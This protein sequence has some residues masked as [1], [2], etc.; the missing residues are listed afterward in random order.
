VA[1][2]PILY[3]QSLRIVPFSET[4][5]TTRYVGWLNDPEV[6]RFS[7]QRHKTHTL[8]S[9]RD[10][11]LSFS[12]T[13]HLLWAIVASEGSLG[14][15]GNVSAYVDQENLLA[16]VGILIGEKRAWRKG[17]G[18][19]AWSAVCDYL[20]KRRGMRKVTAGTPAVNKGMLKIMQQ[21]GMV[22]DGR[23]HRH[24]IFEGKEV[25]INYYAIFQENAQGC[26]S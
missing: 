13:P 24:Y 5:L 17:N 15:I 1:E 9:C 22:L 11:W 26:V 19:E 23:R 3:T 25:D 16:D 6:V 4:F 20:L 7:E 10:Y 14:H 8:D 18:L 21:T 2:G 12:G